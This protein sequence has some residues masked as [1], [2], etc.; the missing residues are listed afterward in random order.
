MEKAILIMYAETN[1]HAG[2]GSSISHIDLPIQRE[3]ATNLPIIQASSIKGVIRTFSKG[4]LDDKYIACLFGPGDDLNSNDNELKEKLRNPS[5]GGGCISFTD[6]NVLLFPVRSFK[7]VVAWI[8]CPLVLK[9]LR[10]YCEMAGIEGVVDVNLDDEEEVLVPE[11]SGVKWDGRVLLEEYF[12]K[13]G[14]GDVSELANWLHGILSNQGCE[15][16]EYIKRNLVVVSDDW[17]K[18]FCENCTEVITRIRINPDTGTVY[19]GALW[20]EESLP[21]ET[22]LW[23][24]ILADK[25]KLNICELNTTQAMD[26]LVELVD[27]KVIQIGGD[28][29]IGKGL[30][31]LGILR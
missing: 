3:R 20:N 28:S 17:F 8:T 29:T 22:V 16:A 23:S 19:P 4:K 9:R 26:K 5:F 21:S 1:I 30:V 25:P 10:K 15:M 2:A 6:A 7:G 13:V 18:Y 14:N 11:N 12:F 27:K 24:F 31:R